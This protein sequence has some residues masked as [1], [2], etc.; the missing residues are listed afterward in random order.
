MYINGSEPIMANMIREKQE[1]MTVAP[2]EEENPFD[3][4]VDEIIERYWR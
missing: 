4:L 2:L 1:T 3:M